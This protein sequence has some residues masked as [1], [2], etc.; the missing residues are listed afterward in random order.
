MRVVR[1]TF[2]VAS[3]ACIGAAEAHAQATSPIN[4]PLQLIKAPAVT[5]GT[6][7]PEQYRLVIN[8]GINGG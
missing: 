1:A 2:L 8:V 7:F 6:P 3:S 4:I 5:T